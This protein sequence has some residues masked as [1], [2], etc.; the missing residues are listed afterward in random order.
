MGPQEEFSLL[1][2][3]LRNQSKVGC[4]HGKEVRWPRETL[5]RTAKSFASPICIPWA[6]EN[7]ASK[8]ISSNMILHSEKHFFMI[9]IFVTK[10]LCQKI[11]IIFFNYIVPLHIPLHTVC[12]CLC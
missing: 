7:H 9:D 1:L 2:R 10:I 4:S 8:M 5:I 11:C 6:I 12:I 3:S